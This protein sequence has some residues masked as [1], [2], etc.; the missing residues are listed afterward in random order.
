M[1]T[2]QNNKTKCEWCYNIPAHYQIIKNEQTGFH[3]CDECWAT[4]ICSECHKLFDDYD[5][6]DNNIT[7]QFNDGVT[8]VTA[9][10]VAARIKKG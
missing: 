1:S 6:N 2:M 4:T 10:K 7:L 9:E 5:I 8:K 3:I